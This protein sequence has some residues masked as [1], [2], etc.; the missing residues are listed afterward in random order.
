MGLSFGSPMFLSYLS[1]NTNQIE[2][3]DKAGEN[4]GN[5]GAEL[6]KDV[7]GRAGGILEGVA[8]GIADNG[9]L[10]LIRAFAAV[11]AAL[12]I[13]LCVIP[14]AAG[15][16]HKY[17]HCKAGYGNAAEK[18]DNAG[19]SE[20]ET[21]DD[22]NNDSENCGNYHLVKSAL[23]AEVNAG[24]VI[25]VSLILHDADDFL[26][27]AANFNNDGLSGGLN[28]AH[29][30]S[31]ED[32][33]EHRADEE[34]DENGRARKREV[35]NRVR[36]FL[37]DV[38]VRNEKSKSGEGSG[39]DCEALAGSGSGVAERVKSVGTVTDFLGKTGH[40]GDAAGVI[41]NRAVSVGSEGDAEGGEHADTGDAN[42][43]KTLVEA[44]LT[45]GAE[46]A[47]YYSG[48]DNEDGGERGLHAERKTADDDGCRAGLGRGGKLLG[49]LVVIGGVIL[50]EVT[51]SAAADKAA[52][53]GNIYAPAVLVSAE[54]EI[55]KGNSYKSGKN[56]GGIGAGAEALEKAELG[57][58]FLGLNEE[59]AD[60]GA[61]YTGYGESYGKE[62]AVPGI[63]GSGGE[64]EGGEDGADIGLVKV[65]AHTGN[66]AD[67]ITD[68]IG[69]GGGVAA[70]ILGDAC[71]NLT[72][73]VSAN[74]RSLGVNAAADAGKQSHEG[75]AHAV[76]DH[77]IGNLGGIKSADILQA[78]E[79][80][81]NVEHTEAD[82]GEAH[83]GTG[84]ESNA[85][86]LVE[87]LGR[88]LRGTGIGVRGYLHA[89]KT[90]EHRPDTAREERKRSDAGEHFTLACK[91]DDE[92]D[93]E[94]DGEHLGNRGVLTLEVSVSA[95]ANG[96]GE[97]FHLVVAF[98]CLHDLVALQESE[99][100]RYYRT[101]KANPKQIFQ[102]ISS[103]IEFM[104]AELPK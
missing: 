11:V 87:T 20:N 16:G 27:L 24:G 52:E 59:G 31:G 19:G 74:V 94:Y 37:N 14:C 103:P 56:S 89:D 70:V 54:D 43:V 102:K 57:G 18:T 53:D 91:R 66:V 80:E 63:T 5:G 72:D 99:N 79:P 84:G 67:V 65:S 88:S 3:Y 40:F 101:D 68:V 33:G 49:G 64:S 81:G 90:G 35:K 41:G 86:T 6:D 69:D 92:Q 73:E 93:N 82:D 10:V 104:K 21:G 44:G 7:E 42:A 75:S 77:N 1:D 55:A 39:A 8:N 36:L 23:G 83:N 50:G 26:E 34:T 17:C 45:A 28:G 95:C 2:G 4:D 97:L 13:L 48:A 38:N 61:D 30:E 96:R 51:D 32:E 25:G 58:V 98:G 15:V 29:G 60:E 9:C 12:D 78:E 62:H 46:E 71:L 76:H 85:K 47:D 22:G 100:E